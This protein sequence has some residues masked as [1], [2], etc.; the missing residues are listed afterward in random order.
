LLPRQIPARRGGTK[1]RTTTEINHWLNVTKEGAGKEIDIV[2]NGTVTAGGSVSNKEEDRGENPN[3]KQ[4][5][6]LK[7]E[8]GWKLPNGKTYWD[9][10]HPSHLQGEHT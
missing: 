1:N 4:Q 6:S 2:Q 10:F 5:L 7:D 3:T 8:D 9:L